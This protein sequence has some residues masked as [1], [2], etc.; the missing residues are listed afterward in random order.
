MASSGGSPAPSPSSNPT[1]TPPFDVQKLFKPLTPSSNPSPNTV[2]RGASPFLPPPSSYPAP[3]LPSTSPAAPLSAFSYPPSTPPFQHRPFLHYP[4]APSPIPIPNP[5]PNPNAGARL[6]ALLG[7]AQPANLESAISMPSPTSP[8]EFSAAPG[9]PP[10]LHPP[11]PAMLQPDPARLPSSKLPRGR[12]LAAGD[13]AVYDV[14]SRLPGESQPPQLEVTPIT[15][16]ISDPGLVLG[17]QIALNRVYICYGLKLGAIRVLNINTALRSLLRG[18]TQ[19]VTDMAF[20]AEDVPLLASASIDGRIFVWKINEDFDD[21][22][23]PQI[24]GKII[25]AIQIIGAGEGEP[26]HPRVCWHPHKQ[27]VLVVGVGNYLLKIDTIKVGRIGQFSAE[28][29]VRCLIDKLIDGVQHIGKHDGEITD[30]S[31][32]QW[33][34]TRLASASKDGKIKIWEDRKVMPIATLTPHDSHPVSSVAFMT[35]PER[36]DHIVLVTAGPLNRELKIW[37]SASEEGWLLP[38]DS[39]SWKCNQTLD[40]RSSTEPRLEEAFFNQFVVLSRASFILLANAKKNAIYALHVDYGPNPAS[41]RMD[42]IAD[43]TVTMPILSF[44]GTSDY[45]SDAEQI[46]QVYCVQTQAIQQ[47]AL[48]LSQCLPIPVENEVSEKHASAAFD[49]PIS[50]GFSVPHSSFG[51]TTYDAPPANSSPAPIL[52]NRSEDNKHQAL[53]GTSEATVVHDH[54]SSNVEPAVSAPQLSSVDKSTGDVASSSP[55]LP[56]NLDFS[57]KLRAVQGVSSA[58]EQENLLSTGSVDSQGHDSTVERTLDAVVTNV[59]DVPLV[60][61][62]SGKEKNK[63]VIDAIPMVPNPHVLFKPDGKPA[64]LV[65]P[66][67]I[68]S[69][70]IPPAESSFPNQGLRSEELDAQKVS[71]K[72]GI[73]HVDG[74]VVDDRALIKHDYLDSEKEPLE[75]LAEQGKLVKHPSSEPINFVERKAFKTEERDAEGIHTLD[76]TVS[77]KLDTPSAAGKEVAEETINKDLP[78]EDSSTVGTNSLPT[79]DLKASRFKENLLQA[80]ATLAP[81]SV[82]FASDSL[83]EHGPCIGNHSTDVLSQLRLMQELLNQLATNQKEIEKQMAEVV[84]APVMKEGRRVE[85]ALGRSMEKSIKANMDSLWAHIQEENAKQE[86]TE[87]ENIQQLTSL[88]TNCINK[89]IPAAVERTIKKEIS[90]VGQVLARAITPSIEKCISSAIGDSFQRGV[91]DK[92]VSQLEKTIGSKLETSLARQIQLQF[93]TSGKQTLQDTLKSTLE[94]SVVPAFEKSS[95]A[96]FEQID[97]AFQKGLTDHTATAQQQYESAH[98]QLAITLRDSINSASSITHNLVSELADGQQ[99]LLALFAT[100]NTKANPIAK[101]QSNGPL[102]HPD[103]A[104]S[105]QQIEAPF[106][107]TKELTRLISERKFDEAFTLALQRSDV[108]IVSWLCSQVDLHGLCSMAPLPLS[109]GVLLALLQQLS[110]DIS[111]ETQRKIS[112]M[113]DVAVAI[114]PTDPMITSHVRPIFEQVY[115]RL[116]QQRTLQTTTVAEA[117]SIRLIIHVINSVLMSCK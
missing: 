35:S 109:Q 105:V 108:S 99:K 117:S 87:R 86:K 7:T 38:S 71:D 34:T 93:Q 85:T 6:M 69:G 32:S 39:E 17:R 89:D 49:G 50:E 31:M 52:I 51:A 18:H 59:P 29:P 113:T 56:L 58:G 4:Q 48:D 116:L 23:K 88:I 1:P 64:H 114:N 19:K 46:V 8:S 79:S 11:P 33:M 40:L 95:R 98:T 115:N 110:C 62:T 16:Y 102:G 107:P 84:C 81:V 24:T 43:F 54:A 41:T 22:S 83:V 96:L 90:A 12:R 77:G 75:A 82:T 100:G 47:Y 103:M 60:A 27:E 91:T 57:E 30:I 15:K 9:N 42:Y 28:E 111:A 37:V 36:P 73:V 55:S 92:I 104:L 65:T 45:I 68:L 106:D 97:E 76:N 10:I 78:F 20:F 94:S 63:A 13:R 112:W 70:V 101:Q 67:E 53:S 44:T 74:K 25:L 80:S 14:D 66:S 2:P 61:E 21:D 26:Y 72:N 5:N 3:L